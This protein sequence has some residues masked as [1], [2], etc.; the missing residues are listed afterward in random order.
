MLGCEC[1]KM[2]QYMDPF[3]RPRAAPPG[4]EEEGK[5]KTASPARLRETVV[6]MFVGGL[7]YLE[8]NAL[9]LLSKIVGRSGLGTE[10]VALTMGWWWWWWWRE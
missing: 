7:T 3:S 10:H 5:G 2:V 9:R 1:D 6:V 4:D 8:L